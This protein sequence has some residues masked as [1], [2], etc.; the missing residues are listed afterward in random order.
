MLNEWL[1]SEVLLI[2]IKINKLINNKFFTE[3]NL[4]DRKKSDV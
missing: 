1:S 4:N 3:R 2:G